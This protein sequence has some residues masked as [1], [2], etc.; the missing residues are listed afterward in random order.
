[1]T[2]L[3]K[4]MLEELQRR[5]LSPITTRIY[6]RAVEEFAHYYKASRPARPEAH[7]AVSGPSVH[8]SQAGGRQ[9]RPATFRLAV[10][11]S[12]D[13]QAPLD[14]GGHPGI[15]KQPIRLPEI[16]SREEVER[17]IQYADSPLHRIWLLT[18]YAT[19]MRREELVQ[20]KIDD[21]DSARMLI[22]I[23]QG[24]GKKDRDVMLSPRLLRGTARLLALGEPQTENLPVPQQRRSSQRRRPHAS[25]SVWDAVQQAAKRAGL[26]KH[27]H[28]HTLRH[29]FATHLLE[30]GADL[31]TIQLLAG[32]C[33]SEDDQPLSP[34]VGAAS[35]SYRQPARLAH[36]R[37]GHEAARASPQ[38]VNE[39][40][41]PGVGRYRSR[42]RPPIHG[43]AS[44]VVHLAA[45][46]STRSHRAMPHRRDGRPSGPVLRLR[47]SRH[48]L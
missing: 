36:A 23:R 46:E 41:T 25:K 3:R 8:R 9:R 42:R 1:M 34:S 26:D 43:P 16:L 21:I 27:V 17:L 15:P 24:K 11:F 14:A 45:P 5:N 22:H 7:P 37:G 6:L 44:R 12:Q 38:E 31:R 10:L 40:A 28:P 19:G 18:L 33:R 47:P 29:C 4:A 35:Q 20:L 30:S 2:H 48:L 39:G 32:P 13:P